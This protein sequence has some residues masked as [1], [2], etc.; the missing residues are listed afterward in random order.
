MPTLAPETDIFRVVNR[1]DAPLRIAW[2]QVDYVLQPSEDT[3]VPAAAC[4]CWFGDPRAATNV[5]S[6]TDPSGRVSWIPDRPTEVRRLRIKYSSPLVG[7][8]TNFDGVAIPDVEVYTV[9]GERITTVLQD[10]QGSTVI[11]ASTTVQSDAELRALVAKQQ[12]ELESMRRHLNMD[13]PSAQNESEI[14]ADDGTP[15]LV[16][17]A[18]SVPPDDEEM[19]L[20][21]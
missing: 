18:G 19:D 12:R 4:F 20:G 13:A 10:P 6:T 11:P 17:S 15:Q 8:E 7:D 21:E 1:G 3:F 5:K 16:H 9:N 14:P 2:N